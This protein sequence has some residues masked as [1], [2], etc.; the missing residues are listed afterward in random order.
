LSSASSADVVAFATARGSL[1]AFG[2]RGDAAWT[3][4]AHDGWA[5][6]IAKHGDGFISCGHD[7]RVLI[8]DA[9]GHVRPLA[10]LDHPLRVIASGGHDGSIHVGDDRGWIHSLGSDGA[11]AALRRAHAGPI[12]ALAHASDGSLV[13]AGED[14]AIKRWRGSCS[15]TIRQLRDHVTSLVVDQDVAIASGYDGAIRRIDL[16][17]SDR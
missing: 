7:G 1:I 15:S 4:D 16:S 14:G 17:A 2:S 3:I 9:T 5:W 13:S 6:S 10:T 12:T 8:I 11:V